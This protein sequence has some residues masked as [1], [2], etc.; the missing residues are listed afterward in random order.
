[1]SNDF[2]CSLLNLWQVLV[3]D[4]SIYSLAIYLP[5]SLW[6][7]DGVIAEDCNIRVSICLIENAGL[8]ILAKWRL[9]SGTMDISQN[10]QTSSHSQSDDVNLKIMPWSFLGRLAHSLYLP[11]WV[12]K[13]W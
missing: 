5:G 3:S 1:M 2:F 7:G 8:R 6:Y 12:T 10:R 11:N 9:D 13:I 4:M